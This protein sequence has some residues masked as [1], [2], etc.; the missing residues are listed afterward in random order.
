MKSLRE[1]ENGSSDGHREWMGERYQSNHCQR[2]SIRRR[3]RRGNAVRWGGEA[4]RRSINRIRADGP[5][6]KGGGYQMDG[7][8]VFFVRDPKV[9]LDI[10]VKSDKIAVMESGDNDKGII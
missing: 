4:T 5:T 2:R 8:T 7:N 10:I 6:R 1:K 9:A 3:R